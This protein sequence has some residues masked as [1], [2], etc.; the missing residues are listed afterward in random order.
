MKIGERITNPGELRTVVTVQN[1]TVAQDT[2]GAQS[3]TWAD[4]ATV[5]AKWTNAHGLEV[6]TSDALASVQRATVLIRYLASVTAKSAIVKDGERWSLVSPPD[7]IQERHEYME[8]VVE[9]T[10]PT[11]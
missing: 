4:V 8:L 9:I 5:Y 2:G 3:P 1:P 7:D 6:V 10:R 11:V